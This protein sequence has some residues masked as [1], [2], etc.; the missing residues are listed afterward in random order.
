M[1]RPT[2]QRA[3]SRTDLSNVNLFQQTV[4]PTKGLI[5]ERRKAEVFCS[6]LQG[7][8]RASLQSLN[9]LSRCRPMLSVGLLM[10]TSYM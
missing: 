3:S 2:Q 6:E 9:I 5:A 10:L 1:A 7:Q 8:G 4:T